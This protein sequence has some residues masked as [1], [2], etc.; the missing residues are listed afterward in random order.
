MNGLLLVAAGAAL[1]AT[2]G[3]VIRSAPEP[4]PCVALTFDDGP[5]P[6][7][8]P[9]VIDILRDAGAVAT[10]F[11]EG[12]WADA[13]PGIVQR[14]V[15]EGHAIGN[16]SWDHPRYTRTSMG[17]VASQAARTDRAILSAVGYAPAL[18]RPPYGAY[19]GAVLE[20]I[21]D[22]T[23]VAWSVD[24][25]DWLN[26]SPA[27]IVARIERDV[28]PGSIIL[29][30]DIHPTTVEALWPVIEAIRAKGLGFATVPDLLAGRC[31]H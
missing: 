27:R 22:R 6:V 25:L 2:D 24:A 18:L 19:N 11:V 9:Q 21:G 15:F 14:I 20:A 8:T 29:M 4:I 1:A 26:K 17:E 16:H 5:D 23:V 31:T 7:T 30:H 12:R 3:P 13:Y 28:R 10:F